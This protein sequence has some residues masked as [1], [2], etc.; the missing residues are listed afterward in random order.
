GPAAAGG[1]GA[2][3]LGAGG[4]DLVGPLGIQEAR[5]E[6]GV[7]GGGAG[8]VGAVRIPAVIRA[9]VDVLGGPVDH[10]GPHDHGVTALG[11]EAAADAVAFDQGGG[12][13][14]VGGGEACAGDGLV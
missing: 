11:P 9:V 10:D 1:V 5:A 14:D 13:G 2:P 3:G 7:E 12:A 8:A 6:L 4:V